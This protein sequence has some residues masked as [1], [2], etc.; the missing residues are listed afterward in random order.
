MNEHVKEILDKLDDDQLADYVRSRV[1]SVP[2]DTLRE[3]VIREVIRESEEQFA[4]EYSGGGKI[5]WFVSLALEINPV[6]ALELTRFLKADKWVPEY[7]KWALFWRH[8]MWA[9]SLGK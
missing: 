3:A 8:A 7:V 2:Y 5:P 1:T 9:N 4:A 6:K